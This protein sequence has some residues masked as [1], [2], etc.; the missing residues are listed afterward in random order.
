M[1]RYLSFL[2]LF[3]VASSDSVM[4]DFHLSVNIKLNFDNKQNVQI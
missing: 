1:C 3:Y 4:S 2:G